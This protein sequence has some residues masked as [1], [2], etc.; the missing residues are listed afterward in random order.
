MDL[1]QIESILSRLKDLR[2]LVV[3]DFF[4]D[5][6]LVIDP[7]KNEISVET[8]LT[9]YQVVDQRLS[10][11]AA[12]TVANNL[13]RLGVGHVIAL[14]IIGDDGEGYDLIKNLVEIGVDTQYLMQTTD[15][16][17]PTYTKPVLLE[18]MKEREINR[19]D[20]KNWTITPAFLEDKIIDIL[21]KLY[22]NVDAIIALDQISEENHGVITERVRK[23]LSE[24]G[25][26]NKDLIVY[27]D[28]RAFIKKFTNIILK[29]NH[30][31]VVQALH[32]KIDG[33]PDLQM[34]IDC[35]KKLVQKAKRPIIITRGALGQIVFSGDT[36]TEVPAVP[37]E[38][39]IDICGAGD[40][41]TTGIV[42]ALCCG[43]SLEDA[44]FLGSII[45]SITIQQIGTTG[46]PLP[47]D[48]LEQYAKY[49]DVCDRLRGELA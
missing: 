12:G 4:L 24:I 42:T 49:I 30:Y 20:S 33:E 34:L 15:R 44:A 47:E 18:D 2:I 13:K 10:A 22:D 40:A 7:G 5:K 26:K 39:P 43:A 14:S 9:A 25:E 28:S 16:V 11:G 31:E 17:T 35:G 37:V 32:D 3:G 46:T 8:G 27:A 6:H 41:T 48:V 29:C 1:K 45:S 36:F 23:V 38:G 19:L 21:Y